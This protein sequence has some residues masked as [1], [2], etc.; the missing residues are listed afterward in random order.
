MAQVQELS[1]LKEKH[2]IKVAE[3][4]AQVDQIRG[5]QKAEAQYESVQ[6]QLLEAG[7]WCCAWR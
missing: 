3:L 2:E 1:L 5:L 4:E 7:M 6:E